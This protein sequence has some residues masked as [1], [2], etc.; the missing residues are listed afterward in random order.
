[1]IACRIT[2]SYG[3]PN[4]LAAGKIFL[5]MK[6]YALIKSAVLAGSALLAGLASA[7]DDPAR[8]RLHLR[9][10]RRVRQ[11]ARRRPHAILPLVPLL[12]SLIH[13]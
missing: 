7:G 9:P 4:S 12:L 8:L 13:I 5:V 2:R 6:R 1:M 10:H 11:P 3:L